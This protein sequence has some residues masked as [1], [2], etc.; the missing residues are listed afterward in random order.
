MKKRIARQCSNYT[1]ESCIFKHAQLHVGIQFG[2]E[3]LLPFWTFVISSQ[4]YGK[5]KLKRANLN[6]KK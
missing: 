4:K 1:I 3:N 5:R 6:I 2:F